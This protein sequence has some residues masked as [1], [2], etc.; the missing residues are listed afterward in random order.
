MQYYVI[1]HS[2]IKYAIIRFTSEKKTAIYSTAMRCLAEIN[3]GSI[4]KNHSKQCLTTFE[5]TVYAIIMP[6]KWSKYMQKKKIY[7]IKTVQYHTNEALIPLTRLSGT[8]ITVKNKMFLLTYATIKSNSMLLLTI[9]A[10]EQ[11]QPCKTVTIK[12]ITTNRS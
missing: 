11:L 8:H 10:N 7:N 3:A 5:T 12:S 4:H 6:C 9:K 2:Y 1:W